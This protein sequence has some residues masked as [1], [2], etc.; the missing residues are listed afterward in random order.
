MY[1]IICIVSTCVT[2]SCTLNRTRFLGVVLVRESQESVADEGPKNRK[3]R[4]AA[5]AKA[6]TAG[7]PRAQGCV[8][9]GL[10]TVAPSPCEA[11]ARARSPGR[12]RLGLEHS[13]VHPTQYT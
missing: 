7:P 11:R 5:N 4:Q 10:P 6:S 3:S 9:T 8:V 1:Y 2:Y 12:V 13:I